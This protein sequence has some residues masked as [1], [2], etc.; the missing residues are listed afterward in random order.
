[1]LD[2]PVLQESVEVLR[3]VEEKLGAVLPGL[4][5]KGDAFRVKAVDPQGPRRE[6]LF[7]EVIAVVGVQDPTFAAERQRGHRENARA[8]E[9]VRLE[10]EDGQVH[11]DLRASRS[12][13]L[14]PA[15][16]EKR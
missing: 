5:Q 15:R 6:L 3:L 1:V 10:V 14:A 12:K 11:R 16:R 4:S 8:L 2:A 9:T 7:R 13:R